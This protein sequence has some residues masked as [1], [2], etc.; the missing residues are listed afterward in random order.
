MNSPLMNL[1]IL[2][3]FQ[4]FAEKKGVSRIVAETREGSFGLLPH[5]LDCVAALEPGILIYETEAEGEVYV[6]VDEGILV[7]AGKEVLVSVRSAIVGTDL[8]QLR[9]AVEREFL[10]LDE[11]EKKMRSVMTKLEIGLMRRLAE[12]RND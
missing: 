6:A 12:F 9:E 2:L 5:R 1:K 3:P 11:S 10:T 4:V 7:K 8:S